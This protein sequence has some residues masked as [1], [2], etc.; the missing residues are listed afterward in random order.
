MV[1]SSRKLAV[2]RLASLSCAA[3]FLCALAAIVPACADVGDSYAVPPNGGGED[4]SVG[5]TGVQGMGAKETGSANDVVSGADAQAPDV[6]SEEDATSP[7]MEAADGSSEPDVAAADR[8]APDTE[9]PDTGGGLDGAATTDTGPEETG[10]LDATVADTS[11]PDASDATASANDGS[12]VDVIAD[13]QLEETSPHDASSEGEADATEKETGTPDASNDV[14]E[15][16]PVLG[17]CLTVG[18]TD[19]VQCQDNAADNGVCTPTEAALVSHDIKLGIA[20]APGPDPAEGC[21][22]CLNSKHFLDDNVM[23]TGNECEDPLVTGTAAECEAV[24]SC[25]LDSGNGTADSSCSSTAVNNCYCGPAAMG[26]ACSSAG[27]AVNGVCVT[28]IVAGLG[29]AISDNIDILKNLESQN[30]A[31]G[32]ADALFQAALSNHCSA[33]FK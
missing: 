31:A 17:P 18:Q 24:L 8:E 30:Y 2:R 5:D 19:C 10:A 26:S 11:A 21:Y 27:S 6:S 25:I 28:Q 16:G 15:T 12:P 33:C 3:S 1:R 9:A 20:T 22:S 7:N 13:T 23:D 14:A 29:F 4:S 32:M